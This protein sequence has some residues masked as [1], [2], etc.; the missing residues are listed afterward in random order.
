MRRARDRAGSGTREPMAAGAPWPAV[1]VLIVLL[2]SAGSAA[3]RG[4]T[5]APGVS[6]PS[7]DELMRQVEGNTRPAT[8]LPAELPPGGLY[9]ALLRDLPSPVGRV[10][11]FAGALDARTKSAMESLISEVERRATAELAIVTVDS[12]GPEGIDGYATRLFNAWGIGKRSRDN[13]VLLLVA[14]GDRDVRIEVG[15]GL[16]SA[17]PDAKAGGILDED[18]VPRFREGDMAGG[19]SAG[20]AAIAELVAPGS[21]AAV[22]FPVR[23]SGGCGASTWLP[24]ASG[25]LAALAVAFVT[26][27]VWR[28]RRARICPACSRPMVRLPEQEEDAFLTDVQKT[29]ESVGSADWDVWRCPDCGH[30]YALRY[31]KW[32]DFWGKCPECGGETLRS[33]RMVLARATYVSTGSG[34]RTRDCANCHFHDEETY[35]IPVR[36]RSTTRT[37][38]GFRSSG[39]GGFGGG[40][41][42]G[43]G[44]SRHW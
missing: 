39:G 24:W 2:P 19:M 15:I 32:F 37:G 17:I 40:R 30:N 8:R 31:D 13:G 16:E 12:T 22:S 35:V 10:N 34:V 43:G 25:G 20:L 7:L 21:A 11:D 26:W 9:P 33:K 3:P 5:S 18:V 23:P 36:V 1:V 6:T 38:G 29:E 28:R 4:G 27:R 44:A 42:G 41:S 14:V